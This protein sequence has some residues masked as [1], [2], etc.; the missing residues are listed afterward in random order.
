[1]SGPSADYWGVGIVVYKYL[2]GHL[3]FDSKDSVTSFT[4]PSCVHS[5]NQPYWKAY[6]IILQ[7]QQTWV[8]NKR[9]LCAIFGV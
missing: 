8:G 3:P 9:C 2:T 5:S 1:M 6:Q 7:L 4:A